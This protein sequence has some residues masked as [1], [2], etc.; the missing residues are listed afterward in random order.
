MAYISQLK[1]KEIKSI[2]DPIMKEYG[3][4]YGLTVSNHSSINCTIKSGSIDFISNVNDVASNNRPD[5]FK[6]ITQ[7]HM[8]VNH[9]WYKDHFTGVALEAITKII[10]AL[11]TDNYDRS[12]SQTDYFDVGHYIHLDIGSW[13]RP[14]ILYTLGE[15]SLGDYRDSKESV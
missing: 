11:N 9:F 6:A 13:D 4:K 3:L 2:L 12:D 1:K 5:L 8:Q 14:Y 15:K 7:D 10:A